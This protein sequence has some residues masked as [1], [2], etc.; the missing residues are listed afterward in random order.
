MRYNTA[1]GAFFLVTSVL[2]Y[3]WQTF[4][5]IEIVCPG[6]SQFYQFVYLTLPVLI[7]VH[8]AVLVFVLWKRDDTKTYFIS[9]T[10]FWSDRGAEA[11]KDSRI[12]FL[13]QAMH[14]VHFDLVVC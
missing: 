5:G 7:L 1:L 12:H 10:C 13:Q 8:V 6:Y 2:V 3:M 9:K 11:D 14:S 4:C